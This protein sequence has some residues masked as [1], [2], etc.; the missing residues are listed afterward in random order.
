MKPRTV[1]DV[2]R[3]FEQDLRDGHR[4]WYLWY[5]DYINSLLIR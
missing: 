5:R 3:S 4:E 2:I 1:K